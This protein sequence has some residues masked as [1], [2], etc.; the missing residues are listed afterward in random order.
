MV[1]S[2]CFPAYYNFILFPDNSAKPLSQE[3]VVPFLRM[4]T[5]KTMKRMMTIHEDVHHCIVYSDTVLMY[6]DKV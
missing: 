1:H 4:A 6:Q 5:K 3:Q 2:I